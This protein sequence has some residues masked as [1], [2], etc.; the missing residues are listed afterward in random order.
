[1]DN[2]A[3]PLVAMRGLKY[4]EGVVFIGQQSASALYNSWEGLY[5]IIECNMHNQKDDR[6]VD[7]TR[8]EYE[9]IRT[10]QTSIMY[11]KSVIISKA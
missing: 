2:K 4:L 3:T 5:I 9:V 1:M 10:Y 7:F 6:E 8:A 11:H